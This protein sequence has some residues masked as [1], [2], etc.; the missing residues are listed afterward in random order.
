MIVFFKNNFGLISVII[1][2][3]W[4]PLSIWILHFDEA[5]RIPFI[6]LCIS[7]IHHYRDIKQLAN[8]TPIILYI[9]VSLI[10]LSNAI[11]NNSSETFDIVK[12]KEWIVFYLLISPVLVLVILTTFARKNFELSINCVYWG[13]F[14][15]CFLALL[16]GKQDEKFDGR[17]NSEI[18]SNVLALHGAITIGIG[19]I[20]K[21]RFKCNKFRDL[22]LFCPFLLILQTGSRMALTMVILIVVSYSFIKINF[23]NV[24][25][26][27][28]G[29]IFF[30][31]A[32]ISFFYIVNNTLIGER[33]LSTTEQGM[34]S[35]LRS[36][37]ILDY[38]G[39][40]GVQYYYSWR[41]FCD[42]PFFG[43]G[44]HYWNRYSPIG[45]VAH[46]ELMVQY[47]ECGLVSFV[48]WCLFW[49]YICKSLNHT[50]KRS[51]ELD[52]K[53]ISLILMVL[54]SMF[55]ANTVLWSYNIICVF[56]MYSF[57]ISF[58]LTIS[59]RR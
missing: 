40:R 47:V 14:I 58:P 25:S 49:Y 10:M 53:T 41:Y 33:L 34:E 6:L 52:R 19:L 3:L 29:C 42:S 17:L 51:N 39:D 28:R 35:K 13:L 44:F 46:S 16:Y 54:L 43:I 11:Y 57:A 31:I 36:G 23:R 37:T 26:L 15:Y 4:S 56:C 50:R 20:L 45:F 27:V 2:L 5:F 59:K 9:I 18:N 7:L 30:I 21:Q 22:S 48:P 1:T 12:H 24:H 55:Y 32:F 8:V 38:Y